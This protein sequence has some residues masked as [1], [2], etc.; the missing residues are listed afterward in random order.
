MEPE[1]SQA[2]KEP[3]PRSLLA[4]FERLYE[5]R[6]LADASESCT[7]QYRRNI[8][9]F[10]E[11]LGHEASTADLTDEN[12][13]AFM[14]TI[15]A[16]GRSPV[17]ANKVRAQ[18]VAL[19]S[20]LA[21]KGIVAT[22]PDVPTLREFKRTPTAW[23]EHELAQ[24]FEACSQETGF[25]AGV[26]AGLWWTALHN[27]LW[28]SGARIGATM[29]LRWEQVDLHDASLVMLAETQKQADDQ[30]F[31]LHPNT[32][33]ALRRIVKPERDLVFPW[34]YHR[35][36]LWNHYSRILKRAGLPHGRRDK[37]HR[38]RRSAASH[39]E[40]AGGNATDL[41]GHSSRRITSARPRHGALPCS[42]FA[43][44]RLAARFARHWR[45]RELGL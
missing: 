4:E 5:P 22:F 19:W 30:A 29:K 14:Q 23:T 6:Q 20:Y 38:M 24:L 11:F 39:F 34:P 42:V 17:T 32:V 45:L 18:I 31:P 2:P 43:A 33:A 28:D 26:Y 15:R 13:L 16:K 8:Y 40:A 27:V 37:F 1:V 21:R 36:S 41:L 44:P 12:V 9:K 10:G 7:S 25:I 3:Q 35:D